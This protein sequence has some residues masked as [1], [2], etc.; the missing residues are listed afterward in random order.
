MFKQLI[1][2]SKLGRPPSE[3]VIGQ[4]RL[5]KGVMRQQKAPAAQRECHT[6]STCGF[7]CYAPVA[8]AESQHLYTKCVNIID[9]M[10]LCWIIPQKDQRRMAS[11]PTLRRRRVCASAP[12][13]AILFGEH[14]VVYGKTAVAVAV[15]DLRIQAELVSRTNFM[16]TPHPAKFKRADTPLFLFDRKCERTAI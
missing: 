3:N 12:G 1:E 14:A 10:T 2:P 13:K 8:D 9:C 11:I 6:C 7:C 15:S 16:Y 4:F 5:L